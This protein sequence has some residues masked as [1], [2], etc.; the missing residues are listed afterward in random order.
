M[1]DEKTKSPLGSNKKPGKMGAL[2][3]IRKS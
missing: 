2:D 3:F 1:K